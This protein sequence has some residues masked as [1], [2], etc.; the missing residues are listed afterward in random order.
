MEFNLISFKGKA[1]FACQFCWPVYFLELCSWME[2]PNLHLRGL[3]WAH[4]GLWYYMTS[5]CRYRSVCSSSFLKNKLNWILLLSSFWITFFL[6]CKV[7][8]A[9]E[10]LKARHFFRKLT[11]SLWAH[12]CSLSFL[13]HLLGGLL[14]WTPL[15]SK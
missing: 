5:T 2:K 9:Q 8:L 7:E 12:T 3:W 4:Y 10:E 6:K 13:E 15:S 1:Y 14:Q 11:T